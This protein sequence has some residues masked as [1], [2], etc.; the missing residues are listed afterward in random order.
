MIPLIS[1]LFIGAKEE[2]L[3]AFLQFLFSYL[4]I[5]EDSNSIMGLVVMT[6]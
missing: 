6:T 5:L 2:R 4:N 3:N 1:L